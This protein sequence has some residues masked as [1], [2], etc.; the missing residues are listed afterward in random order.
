LYG[1]G[2]AKIGSIVGGSNADGRRLKQSFMQK[3]PAISYLVSAVKRKVEMDNTLKGLDG[4][5]LPCRSPHS[6]L[7]LLLQ[8]A[9]AVVMKQALVDFIDSARLPYELHG[10]IHDEVQF[11][12][13]AEHADELGSL[14]C[15]SLKTAGKKLKFR[16]PLD[17]EYSI[18]KTWAETH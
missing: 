3:I 17:G 10:N 15:D 12:C 4:R 18:G 11:S 8:S 9:G 13:D 7:N 1:A 14:F 6:A 2:D 16:C 5:I